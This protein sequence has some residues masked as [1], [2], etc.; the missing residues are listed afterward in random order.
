MIHPATVRETVSLPS[1]RTIGRSRV[2][3][4]KV[5]DAPEILIATARK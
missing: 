5:P 1:W 4:V 3:P 2:S